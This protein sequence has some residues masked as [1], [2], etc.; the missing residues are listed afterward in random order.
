MTQPWIDAILNGPADP[1]RL[2]A[3]F[4]WADAMAA[5]PQ[6]SLY[7]AEGDVWT[8]TRMVSAELEA[9]EGFQ[10]LPEPRRNALR[11]AAWFHDVAKPRT[12]EISWC[13]VEKRERVRQP[14]HAPVG[15]GMAWQALIDAGCDAALARDVHAL[16][17]W[18][19]R[20]S[21]FLDQKDP[22]SRVIRFTAET[23]QTTWSDLLRFCRSDQR[24]RISPNVVE[25]LFTLDLVEEMIREDGINAEAD[26]LEQ[27]WPFATPAAR[28]RAL[29]GGKDA[30][31]WFTPQEPKGS[32]MILLS[33]LPG[34][35]KDTLAKH[36]FPDLPVVSLD[37][38]REQLG[39]LPT[40][41]QGRVRQAGIE[42]ARV[43]LRRK[44]DFIW[45]ATCVSRS[46]REKIV[47]IALD[48][49]AKVEAHALDVPLAVAMERN[50]KRP[51]PVPDLVIAKI[52]AKREPIGAD[53]AHEVWSWDLD[54]IPRQ[55]L[56]ARNA[57]PD[58]SLPEP[59]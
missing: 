12:T 51:D 35:G 11:L 16:V 43:H 44:E 58:I 40:E 1:T 15:A 59:G 23:A 56:S 25:G 38:I 54:Q 7:H 13:D 17:F 36:V 18:H 6:D 28:L 30:S 53:E 42:A 57:T 39:I 27:P 4:P 34:S 5:C 49:D 21:H 10:D 32:R 50:R 14:Y 52:A 37:V 55:I 46:T 26:L 19:Q 33:G 47:G 48:Y 41:D 3:I 24:G 31:P 2:R 29:R 8:H 45:N 22:L 20:P 9:S